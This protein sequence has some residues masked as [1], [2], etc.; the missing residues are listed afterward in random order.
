[1]IS[2]IERNEEI[3]R[4]RS[5]GLSFSK[6]AVVYGLTK[7]QIHHICSGRKRVHTK[8]E[9]KLRNIRKQAKAESLEARV[10]LAEVYERFGVS[11]KRN[12]YM[13][14]LMEK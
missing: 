9:N 7:Q 1:M 4:L 11:Y 13:P 3:K 5:T 6:I 14:K 8:E 2:K 10:P 12:A